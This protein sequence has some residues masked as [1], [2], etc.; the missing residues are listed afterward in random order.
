MIG[1]F[2]EEF[3]EVL[4]WNVEEAMAINLDDADSIHTDIQDLERKANQVYVALVSLTD[5]VSNDL[6]VGS[7]SGEWT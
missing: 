4:Q 1:A 6:V 3:R 5:S 7:G 2:R